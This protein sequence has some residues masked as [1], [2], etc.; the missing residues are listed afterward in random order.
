ML[1]RSGWSDSC[2]TTAGST[3]RRD[4][5]AG[6]GDWWVDPDVWPEGLTPIATHVRSLGMQF[7]LWFEPEM[8]N[9]DSELYRAHPDWV[10]STGDRVPQLHRN[11]LVLDLSRPEVWQHVHD[12]VSAV[13]PSCPDRLR[14]VGPQP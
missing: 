8:V 5:T 14:Q 9:P 1:P 3:G 13:S 7:G 12:Q 4:D 11:Q 6:L 10:L 2:W